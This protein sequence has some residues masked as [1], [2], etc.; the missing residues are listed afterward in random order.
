[1]EKINPIIGKQ[2]K[3]IEIEERENENIFLKCEYL[4]GTDE[5]RKETINPSVFWYYISDNINWQKRSVKIMDEI[6]NLP[7][8][9]YIIDTYELLLSE[10][11]MDED[12]QN[13]FQTFDI[14]DG[15]QMR[16]IASH[17]LAEGKGSYEKYISNPDEFAELIL[18]E[19]YQDFDKVMTFNFKK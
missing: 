4:E 18:S 10:F 17:V 13:V 2:S 1:M 15:E 7:Y 12:I 19:E 5:E 9:E 11:I 8:C 3:I 14:F 16:I 6:P